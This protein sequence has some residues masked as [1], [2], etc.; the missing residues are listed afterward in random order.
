MLI[1]PDKIPENISINYLKFF[2]DL[3]SEYIRKRVN[4]EYLTF[5][6]DSK[7]SWCSLYLFDRPVNKC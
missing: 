2:K 5:Y 4:I 1:N 3:G 6:I 7:E